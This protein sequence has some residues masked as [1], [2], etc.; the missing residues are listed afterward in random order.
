MPGQ[1]VKSM[2]NYGKSYGAV[3]ASLDISKV[4]YQE[5]QPQRWKK[6]FNLI[7][8]TKYDAAAVAAKLFPDLP[9][10]IFYG[11][12]G[13][14]LDGRAEALLIAEYGRRYF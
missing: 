13:G 6:E 14:L 5:I 3:L 12:R 11:P 9:K 4:P 2:F 8:K 10:Y 1:G 7:K